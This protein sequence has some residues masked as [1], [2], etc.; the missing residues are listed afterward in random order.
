MKQ[1]V[2][3]GLVAILLLTVGAGLTLAKNKHYKAWL[4]VYTQTVDEDLAE[5]FDLPVDRGAIVNGIVEDSPAEK[6]GLEEDDIIIAMGGSKI[7]DQNDL[8]DLVGDTEP[9]DE[10]IVTVMRDDKE[11]EF[12]AVID[13]WRKDNDRFYLKDSRHSRHSGNFN[14]YFSDEERAYIGV[15]L[16]EVS[17]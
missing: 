12:T 8:I 1:I 3:I 5:A 4:G 14:L 15:S 10:V 2:K 6:C 17:D 13:K 9:G 16:I 11:Q 7:Y